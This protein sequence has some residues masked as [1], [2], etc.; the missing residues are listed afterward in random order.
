MRAPAVTPTTQA[1]RLQNRSAHSGATGLLSATAASR[2]LRGRVERPRP[3]ID[4]FMIGKASMNIGPVQRLDARGRQGK[5]SD[6]IEPHGIGNP[7]LT[8]RQIIEIRAVRGT[9]TLDENRRISVERIVL[10]GGLCGLGSL[11]GLRVSTQ[12][13]TQN[14]GARRYRIADRDPGGPVASLDIEFDTVDIAARP[15]A[16][17][18]LLHWDHAP[19]HRVAGRLRLGQWHA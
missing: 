5:V 2:L 1:S 18:A 8:C 4:P 6:R 10:F 13:R 15:F 7:H 17:L 19:L 9:A 11:R 14:R 3:D 16:R 12:T